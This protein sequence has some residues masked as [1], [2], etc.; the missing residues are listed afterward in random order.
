MAAVS[1]RNVVKR[2]GSLLAN[3]SISFDIEPGTIHLLLGENGAGKTTLLSILTGFLKADAGEI[4]I[5]GERFE[6]ATPAAALQHG[7]GF[8]APHFL[9]AGALSGAEEPLV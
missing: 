2:F 6:K 9:L 3:D 1:F 4:W 7:V 8:C 5:D